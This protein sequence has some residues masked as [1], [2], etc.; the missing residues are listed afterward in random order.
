M[1]RSSPPRL[2]ARRHLIRMVVGICAAVALYYVLPFDRHGIT[3][4]N[5]TQITVAV[6][7]FLVLVV[8]LSRQARALVLGGG[9][10]AQVEALV[11][12]IV[13]VVLFFSL[14]YLGMAD[15]FADLRDKTDA[16]YF[17]VST[18]AT[19]GFGDVHATGTAARVTVTIQMVFDL[20]YLAA[21]ASVIAGLVRRRV[22]A[23][24]GDAPAG[25]PPPPPPPPAAP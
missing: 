25:P 3:A 16:L 7:I 9:R 6:V 5:P 4:T 13:L 14:V 8:L 17:T 24:R 19:V 10:P 12:L 2:W 20:V 11:L 21:L 23:M 1:P 22:A 18:L 15:Q